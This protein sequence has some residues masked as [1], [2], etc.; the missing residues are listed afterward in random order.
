MNTHIIDSVADLVKLVP[1]SRFRPDVQRRFFAIIPMYD[2]STLF[3][4][5][6][7]SYSLFEIRRERKYAKPDRR[8]VGEMKLTFEDNG[9]LIGATIGDND[10]FE[11][12]G[13]NLREVSGR[14]VMLLR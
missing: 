3:V 14:A 7:R 9:T 2:G 13:G 10:E 6:H 12:H 1:S 4:R 5:W 8:M 11:V